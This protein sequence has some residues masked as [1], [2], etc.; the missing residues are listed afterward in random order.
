MITKFALIVNLGIRK[1]AYEN[2]PDWPWPSRSFCTLT[3][4]RDP[5]C[6]GHRGN[7]P[8]VPARIA[9]LSPSM[10]L[11]ISKAALENGSDCTL[12]DK[13][14]PKWPCHCDNLPPVSARIVQMSLIMHLGIS[15]TAFENGR[16]WFWPS[17]SFCTLTHKCGHK[18]P[19]HRDNSP[20]FQLW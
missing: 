17:R 14:A 8:L 9:K 4:K 7:S 10:H 20:L 3:N 2:G 19:C 12:T 6:R 1:A 16:D 13:C 11:G 5:K 15:K 18:G